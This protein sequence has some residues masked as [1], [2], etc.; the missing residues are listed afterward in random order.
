[1]SI[2]NTTR[3]SI[4][5]HSKTRIDRDLE[6]RR[7]IGARAREFIV[8]LGTYVR[9][10]RVHAANNRAAQDTLG[11]LVTAIAALQEG[12]N[13]LTIV[14]AEGHSFVN[15]VWVRTTRAV[16]DMSVFL[17]ET[18]LRMAARGISLKSGISSPAVADLATI[19]K[20]FL[21]PNAPIPEDLDRLGMPG[22]TFLPIP[23][24]TD[25]DDLEAGR[26]AAFEALREGLMLANEGASITDLDLFM[27][28]RQR[29][30]VQ[31]LVQLAEDH[32]ENLLALTTVRD[33]NSVSGSHVFMVTVLA[34]ALGRAIGLNRAELL[35]LGIASLNQNIG[36]A[37][38]PESVFASPRELTEIEREMV[39][40]HAL[41]GARFVLENYGFGAAILDRAIVTSE[42]HMYADGRGGYPFALGQPP[43]LFAR[44]VAVCDVYHALASRRPYRAPFPP[45]QS[46]KLMRRRSAKHIDPRLVRAFVRLVG[47]YPPGTLVE[48][49]TG[50]FAIV[51]GLGAG[52]KPMQRPRV[53]LISGPDGDELDQFAEVDLGERHPRR[54][55][56]LRTI[57]RTRHPE[58][59][60]QPV[61]AYL[62]ADR[63]ILRSEY[64]DVAVMK[65]KSR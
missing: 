46:I 48:L 28:R 57:M 11:Q 12:E 38:L 64:L 9:Q 33:A 23:D 2:A 15:G 39:K 43:H 14:F 26:E 58:C 7:E 59:L 24:A 19:L 35:R 62:F 31:R 63:V 40:E 53:I 8:A 54:R 1:M 3:A 44:I 34:I 47:R 30:L 55:A 17:T 42:H 36:Q 65:P 25:A 5:T 18:L 51:V 6:R 4:R 16:W 56:W 13:D 50:E 49:D 52:L 37:L 61:S 10:L 20:E 22:V 41:T 32:P 60:G 29:G 45:D 21:S 27:R